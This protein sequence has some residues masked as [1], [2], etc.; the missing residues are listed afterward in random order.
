MPK[1]V[2]FCLTVELGLI[3][4]TTLFLTQPGFIFPV[5]SDRTRIALTMSGYLLLC[6]TFCWS[7]ILG[8][9]LTL[10]EFASRI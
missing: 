3:F 5:R 8:S 6:I 4:V 2:L 1:Q 7:V 10:T 9:V